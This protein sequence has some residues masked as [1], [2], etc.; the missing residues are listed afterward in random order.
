[1]IKRPNNDKNFDNFLLTGLEMQR[2]LWG[3][4]C[5]GLKVNNGSVDATY[6]E[7]Q[8]ESKRVTYQTKR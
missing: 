2:P 6:T 7:E 5:K 4:N 1:M 3:L 8:A